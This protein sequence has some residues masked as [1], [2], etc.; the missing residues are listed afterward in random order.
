MIGFTKIRDTGDWGLRSD[1]ELEPGSTVTVS[2]RNGTTSEG[3]V[4]GELVK[5]W[6][7]GRYPE[8]WIYTIAQENGNGDQPRV[9]PGVFENEH[10]IFVV[11][12]NQERTGVYAKR[13]VELT[14]A[15]GDRVNEKDE[16]VRIQFEYARGA[17]QH[18]REEHRMDV[19]RGKELCLK[20]RRCIRCGRGLEVKE[21][22]ERGIGPVCIK[23]FRGGGGAFA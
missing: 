10:G 16:A 5:H 3:I 6:P 19:E 20:Y 2:K 23:S 9:E 8:A 18:I 11:V 21:S 12:E 7:V 22:V 4:V 15:Q 14:P 13:M 17:I 1:S